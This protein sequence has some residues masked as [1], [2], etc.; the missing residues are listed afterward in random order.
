MQNFSRS[1][2]APPN[3]LLDEQSRPAREALVAIFAEDDRT[4]EGRRVRMNRYAVD[5][6]D[7]RQGLSRLFKGKCAFCEARVETSPYRF[8]PPEEAGPSS[9]AP[10]EASHLA[11]L[12]YVWLVND[13][14]NIYPVCDGCRPIEPSIFPIRSGRRM[15][16]PESAQIKLYASGRSGTWPFPE[17]EL[18]VFLDPSNDENFRRNLV[19][20]P[21][22]RL[23]GSTER[24]E[25]TVKH[26]NLN[27]DD[28]VSR[29]GHAFSENL[30][31]LFAMGDPQAVDFGPFKFLDVE[32]GG[33]WY[34]MLYQLAKAMSSGSS[35]AP[36]LSSGA[37]RDYFIQRIGSS[38]FRKQLK[39][40]LR[41]FNENPYALIRSRKRTRV[42]M[43]GRARPIAF[44]IENFRSIEHLRL[45]MPAPFSIRSDDDGEPLTD[46]RGAGIVEPDGLS[47]ALMILGENAVGK[48][49]ALE[50]VAYLLAGDAARSDI[51]IPAGSMMLDPE[52]LGGKGELRHCR[53]A[54]EF[55][56]GSVVELRIRDGEVVGEQDDDDDRTPVFAYGAFRIFAEEQG[57]RGPG[58]DVV[59]IFR[60]E[61]VLPNPEKWLVGIA[62]RPVF[63]DV[64]RALNQILAIDDEFDGIVVEDQRCLLVTSGTVGDGSR[65][66]VRTP[67]NLVSS[68]FRSVLSMACHVIRG[69]IEAQDAS[70]AS[71]AKARAVV[72]IDE[73]EAH[74]HPRWKMRV[75]RGLREALPGVT[76]LM[77]AHDPLCLR[78]LSSGEIVVLK[79]F[80]REDA[81]DLPSSVEQMEDLPP[82]SALT[83]QQLLTS[84]FFD[85]FSTDEVA[86]EITLARAGDLLA[87]SSV[88]A[89]GAEDLARLRHSIHAQV[90]NALPI[91]STEIERL[92]QEAVEEYLR[93]RAKAPG[94]LRRTLRDETRARIVNLLGRL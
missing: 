87:T 28:L 25:A 2:V 43:R 85:L 50:A 64:R 93:E 36:R 68:G 62:Q 69:L 51:K 74:L 30:A 67:L 81:T 56:D 20:A 33:T 32:F 46:F 22:G 53:L 14:S 60:P 72:L 7:L 1:L 17:T 77:T 11:H 29:R 37:I 88:D 9:S 66:K 5:D 57:G 89:S 90:T 18:Q 44:I 82:A 34:L 54:A 6:G 80:F 45:E 13:W 63:A 92:V 21:D 10:S 4:L 26:F 65:I 8:R 31:R 41:S 94:T 83:V 73:V 78:G 3:S 70:S 24:G 35:S 75:V 23:F 52:L 42:V 76:F 47:P 48:S 61:H 84:D 59:S 79:R 39:G 12:Y 91:G 49:S 55:E 15:K 38:N 86:T 58:S 27:R 19:V 16:L 71:L 40:T